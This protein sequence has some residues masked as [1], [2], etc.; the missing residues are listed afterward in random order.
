[1]DLCRADLDIAHASIDKQI[2]PDAANN[3]NFKV[4]LTSKFLACAWCK[5]CDLGC[6]HDGSEC[7]E[8]PWPHQDTNH[9]S[10]S[11]AATRVQKL[12]HQS[13]VC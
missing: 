8:S 7:D 6:M 11:Q 10:V 12:K 2:L 13:G 5:V 3:V 4:R 9:S 1:M